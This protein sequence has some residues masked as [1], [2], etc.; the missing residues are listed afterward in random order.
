MT[1]NNIIK[2][3]EKTELSESQRVYSLFYSF[4]LIPLML[5]I[6]GVLFYLLFSVITEEPTNINQ[7]LNKLET[8]SMRDK[9]NAS[10]NLN[11]IFFNDQNKYDTIYRKRIIKIYNMTQSEYFIDSTL[12]LHAI[13]IMGNSGD[14]EFGSIL[15]K[16]LLS[17]DLKNAKFRIKAIE[18]LGK[19]RY[20][21]SSNAIH[22]FLGKEK[23]FLEKLAAAGA[24]GNIGN[25]SS[26]QPLINL[27]KGWPENWLASDGPELRWE[28]AISLLK[29]GYIDGIT[30]NLI[31]N[32]INRK[33]L[34]D[35]KEYDREQKKNN[36]LNQNKIDFV[37]LK[38]LTIIN[39]IDDLSL[40]QPFK[41]NIYKLSNS[42]SNLEIRD[43]AKKVYSRFN[44]PEN[45]K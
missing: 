28:A 3:N 15:I 25:K 40:T 23:L 33:Y 32:L 6:F 7:L 27:I 10:Y 8:G 19:L 26:I 35:V 34:K 20:A 36:K 13:M 17:E 38:I 44:Y 41:D 14:S 2:D 1:D 31:N 16:E 37:I 12:R 11:K 22:P 43:F 45:V 5:V 29:L 9:S 42:D 18:S 4:F 30:Q 39:S 21:K 24:L